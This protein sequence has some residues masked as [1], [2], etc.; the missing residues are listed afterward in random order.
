VVP[1]RGAD[2][3]G[4]APAVIGVDVGTQGVRVVAVDGTGT[5]LAEAA[6]GWPIRRGD[7]GRHEQDP[8]DWEREVRA[9]LGRVAAD[10]G[11]RPVG[12]LAVT[13]TSGTVVAVDADG[14]PLGPAI[15]YDDRRAGAEADEAN[16]ALTDLTG[17]LGY[18]F[19]ASFGLPKM[20]W[21]ARNEPDVFERARWLVHAADWVTGRLTGE[22][23]VA[24]HTNVLKSG[25]DLLNDRWPPEL[26]GLGV[27]LAKLPRVVATGTPVGRLAVDVPGLDRGITVVAGPTDSNAAQVASG[28]AG[29]GQW[30]SALGSTLAL[31]GVTDRLIKDPAGALYCHRHPEGH[32]L[33]GGASNVGGNCLN[34]HFDPGDFARL[35][36]EVAE[37]GGPSPVL[38]YPLVGRG[39]WFPVWADDAEGFEIGDGDEADRFG[40]YLEGVAMVE[41]MAYDTV[42]ALGAEVKG[43]IMATGGGARSGVWTQ[44]RADVLG[45]PIARAELPEAAMGAAVVA[46]SAGLHPGLSA[47]AAAMV[48]TG[49]PVDPRPD[50]TAAY[51]ERY[52][53]LLDALDQRGW[54]DRWSGRS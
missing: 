22:W 33:P 19:R 43:P 29:P 36:R 51:D 21:L 26:E 2:P 11:G 6:S 49:D 5:R 32:W 18:R 41:R 4:D 24:D 17:R 1:A 42:R 46:A 48:S 12:A 30:S 23:A 7:D 9:T 27:P 38:V 44:I 28:A 15:M 37:R 52:G 35:D 13:S 47:A 16:D 40:G 3:S 14:D 39:D 10:L 50:R 45:L 25:Y 53:E 20:L 54:L 34:E 31:K 8:A